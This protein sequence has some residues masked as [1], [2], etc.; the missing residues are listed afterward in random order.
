M[1]TSNYHFTT[2]WRVEST[3]QEI[4]ELL[5]NGREL[6]RWWPAVYLEYVELAPG[7][8]YGLGK[9]F[10]FHTKGWMPYTLQLTFHRTETRY[11]H[12]FTLQVT[13]DLE[14]TGVWKFEQ[15]GPYVHV[16]YDWTVHTNK[17]LLKGLEFL[18]RPLFESNHRWCMNRGET[19]L[20][21]ELARR[22]ARSPEE[23][24]RVPNPP[25]P[26]FPHNLWHPVRLLDFPERG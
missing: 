24:A 18:L 22:H 21:L 23:A 11:P 15:H 3:V 2:L 7:G 10:K 19:S 17:P 6:P 20:T 14:G 8:K 13:G 4:Y 9:R 26:S 16:H 12:G 5:E 25:G 1:Q